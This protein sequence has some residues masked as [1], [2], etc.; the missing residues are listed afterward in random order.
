MINHFLSE[1]ARYASYFEDLAQIAFFITV[2]A[3]TV[4]T[5]R[6]ARLTLLQPIRTEI[7]KEQVKALSEVLRFFV[8]KGESALRSDFKMHEMLQA[9]SLALMD[10]YVSAFFDVEIDYSKRPYC[11]PQCPS[12]MVSQEAM[13]QDFAL[14]DSHVKPDAK[15]KPAPPDPRTRAALWSK[16]KH[17]VIHLPAEFS[18]KNAEFSQMSESP[19]LPS[20]CAALLDEY[21]VLIIKNANLVGDLLTECAQELPEKYPNIEALSKA[22]IDWIHARYTARFVHLEPKAKEIVLFV[23]SY[24]GVDGIITSE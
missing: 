23:R 2:G 10:S 20:R 9:N 12:A 3:V 21:R 8:G 19:I 22:S 7:F 11:G 5:Y 24:F 15:L 13:E 18:S 4:L 6:K 17:G 16:H 14:C 1:A